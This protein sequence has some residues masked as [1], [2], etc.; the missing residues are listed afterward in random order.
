MS[1]FQIV[2]TGRALPA[3]KVTNED[4]AKLVETSDEWIK[5][6]T[7]ISE[8]Y[9]CKEESCCSLAIKA[10]G[11]AV[12]RGFERDAFFCKSDIGLVI[13]AT[14]TSDYVFP[15]TACVVAKSLELGTD[16]M[17]FDI[18]AACSGFM[19][20][21]RTAKALLENMD[22]KYA[23]VVGSEQMSKLLDFTDRNTCVLFGDGSGAALVKLDRE[24]D[25][26]CYINS[27]SEGN[28]EDL[29]CEGIGAKD[30]YLKMKGQSVFKFAVRVIKQSIDDVLEKTGL[31]I[32]D[33]DYV[34][35]HQANARIID[36]VKK[37]Y[38]GGEHK[39]FQNVEKYANTSAASIGIAL[40]ELFVSGSIREG[41]K[42]ICVG[43]G[44]G[45]TWSAGVFTT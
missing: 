42:I 34:V 2:A 41:M 18:N 35:C 27:F 14:S 36:H 26:I 25:G 3:S 24:K 15:S 21:L 13:A 31:S 11:E 19:Y 32:N 5:T 43:F 40:D 7:G 30:N 4:M 37:Q 10:A 33:I 20:A 16:V 9:F 44:A 6:R 39:F 45:L 12:V 23:L 8:R 22:K 28:N 1:L 29:L 38:E 17:S